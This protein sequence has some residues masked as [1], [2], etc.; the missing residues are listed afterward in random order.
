MTYLNTPTTTKPFDRKAAI[1]LMVADTDKI[2]EQCGPTAKALLSD[3]VHRL[4]AMSNKE[5][6]ALI[7]LRG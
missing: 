7:A 6:Q 2:L 5:L 3:V 1:G 4:N